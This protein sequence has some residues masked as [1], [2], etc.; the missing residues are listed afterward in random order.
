A[1]H[2]VIDRSELARQA[3]A[4]TDSGGV[5]KDI[6]TKDVGRTTIGP[7][8]RGEDADGGRFAGAIWAKDAIDAARGHTKIEA[9]QGARLAENLDETFG[10]DCKGRVHLW[11]LLS[12]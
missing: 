6:V 3:N 1:G 5:F 4:P 8:E 12:G 11:L 9:I 10:L 2:V 7:Q